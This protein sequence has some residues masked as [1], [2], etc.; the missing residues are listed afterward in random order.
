MKGALHVKRLTS[1]T[2]LTAQ[3]CGASSHHTSAVSNGHAVVHAAEEELALEADALLPASTHQHAD[4]DVAAA[5]A[6]SSIVAAQS[7]PKDT[8]L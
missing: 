1:R 7:W 6:A 3:T 2:K 8:S 5:A 4:Q